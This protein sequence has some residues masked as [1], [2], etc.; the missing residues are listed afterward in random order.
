[1]QEKPKILLVD[2][3]ERILRSLSMLLRTQYQIFATSDGH[4]ALRILRQEKIH[5]IIS[6]Q[7]MPIMTGTELLSKAKE[8][9]PDTIRI[10]LT[11]YSDADAALDALNDGEIFRYINKP[12][13]PKEL[14]E[15]IAQAANIAGKLEALPSEPLLQQVPI[16]RPEIISNQGLVCLVL[17]RDENTY[18][19]VKEILG[20]SHEVVWSQDVNSAL[21][22]LT[23]R[24][25]AIMVTELSLGDVDLSTMIKTLKQEHPELLTIILTNFKDTARLVELINQAQVF[26]YLPKPVRKGLLGKSIESSIA[27]YRTLNAQPERLETQVVESIQDPLQKAESNKVADFLAQL[28]AK[29]NRSLTA[30]L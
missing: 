13:G 14:R 15:T 5:V 28:R 16:L 23:S 4:E 9:A 12:W 30:G 10:L 22:I 26:R 7:R 27:R 1:M 6:D 24:S 21:S 8:I 17:D 25:V 20:N 18:L 3:E 11:G 2:D 29:I 19:V